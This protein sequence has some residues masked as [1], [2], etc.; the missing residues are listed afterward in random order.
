LT[1]NCGGAE[2]DAL[3]NFE[4]LDLKFESLHGFVQPH[5]NVQSLPRVTEILSEAAAERTGSKVL[6]KESVLSRRRGGRGWSDIGSV[7]I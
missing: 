7:F 2:R 1:A 4:A 6:G 3:L 5:H